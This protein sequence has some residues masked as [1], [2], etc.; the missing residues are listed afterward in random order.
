M[1]PINFVRIVLGLPAAKG[2]QAGVGKASIEAEVVLSNRNC[3]RELVSRKQEVRI[4]N[5]SGV[6]PV[7]SGY[8]TGPLGWGSTVPS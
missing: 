1:A 4:S 8:S 6:T 5:C 2:L 7:V 3:L